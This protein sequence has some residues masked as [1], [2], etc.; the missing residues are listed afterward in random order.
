MNDEWEIFLAEFWDGMPYQI[1]LRS[2]KDRHLVILWQEWRGRTEPIAYEYLTTHGLIGEGFEEWQSE[3]ADKKEWTDR[4]LSLEPVETP[5][6]QKLYTMQEFRKEAKSYME[7]VE[8]S[9]GHIYYC[10]NLEERCD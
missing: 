3:L 6:E 4:I 10:G 1:I 2:K 9:D 8:D 7:Y 5:P